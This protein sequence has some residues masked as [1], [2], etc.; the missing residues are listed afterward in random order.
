VTIILVIAMATPMRVK[1]ASLD[2]VDAARLGPVG[3]V[4]A[5]CDGGAGAAWTAK[6]Y[7]RNMDTRLR[8]LGGNSGAI[9]N[10]SRVPVLL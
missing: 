4:E 1:I 8:L 10:R 3:C 7:A 5:D 2:Q 6:V 9:M